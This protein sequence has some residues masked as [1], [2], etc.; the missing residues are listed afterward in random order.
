MYYS[1]F[2]FRFLSR[3][4]LSWTLD[5]ITFQFPH[6]QVL[7]KRLREEIFLIHRKSFW[8]LFTAVRSPVKTSASQEILICGRIFC[9]TVVPLIVK[10]CLIEVKT[11]VCMWMVKRDQPNSTAPTY[12]KRHKFNTGR[13]QL[14]WKFMI[15]T[16]SNFLFKQVWSNTPTTSPP[17]GDSQLRWRLKIGHKYF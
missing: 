6:N 11:L 10:K 4:S 14:Y 9:V 17:L 13:R 12:I 7:T 8:Y 2:L 5:P 16:F 1:F 3:V 15:L